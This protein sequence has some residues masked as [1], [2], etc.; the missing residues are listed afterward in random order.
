M[1]SV[2]GVNVL[3][4]FDHFCASFFFIDACTLFRR[5][6]CLLRTEYYHIFSFLQSRT[7]LAIYAKRYLLSFFFLFST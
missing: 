3:G 6:L 4:A 2:P 1:H 5:L 7:I